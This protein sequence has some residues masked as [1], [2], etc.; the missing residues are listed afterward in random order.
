[1]LPRFQVFFVV[2]APV[3]NWGAAELKYGQPNG[4]RDVD[5]SVENALNIRFADRPFFEVE[6]GF[7]DGI[8]C[9]GFCKPVSGSGAGCG[10]EYDKYEQGTGDGVGHGGCFEGKNEKAG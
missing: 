10:G 4:V 3:N 8:V 1:L 9:S 5:F 2:P 7:R 6:Q